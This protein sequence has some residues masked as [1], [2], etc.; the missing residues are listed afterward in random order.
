MWWRQINNPYVRAKKRFRKSQR[1]S[2]LK[3]IFTYQASALWLGT[4]LSAKGTEM[5]KQKQNAKKVPVRKKLN[6]LAQTN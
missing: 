1:Y 4:L 6:S 3:E 2:L 5:N